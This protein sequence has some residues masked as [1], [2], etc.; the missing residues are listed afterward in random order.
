MAIEKLS[1]FQMVVQKNQW[2]SFRNKLFQKGFIHLQDISKKM[3]PL[4]NTSDEEKTLR[5]RINKINYLLELADRTNP[6][7][8]PFINNFIPDRPILEPSSV[9]K[10]KGEDFLNDLFEEINSVDEKI[11]SSKERLAF[12]EQRICQLTPYEHMAFS[13]EKLAFGRFVNVWLVESKQ[14]T[15]DDLMRL[16][17]FLFEDAMVQEVPSNGDETSVASYVV[18]APGSSYQKV[19]NKLK[20][21]DLKILP[22]QNL[23]GTPAS[24]LAS[25]KEE[26]ASLI[27]TIEES[28]HQIG[29][30]HQKEPH[31]L[32]LK[33]LC[34][35]HL[36]KIEGARNFTS[37]R[38]VV[39]MEGYIPQTASKEAKE[40]LDKS[41]PEVFYQDEEADNDAPIKLNN[42]PFFAPFEFLLRMFGLPRYGMIDPTPVVSFLFLIFFGIAFG[43]VL[44]GLFLFSV[45]HLM[46]K[47]YD[48]DIGTVK[49]LSMFKYAGISSAFFGMI[50]TSWAGDLV[51]TYVPSSWWLH[52]LHH[53]LGI[54]SA[55]EHVMV[56]MVAIIYLGVIA[57]MIAVAM[58]MFQNIKEKKWIDAIFDQ[59]SWMLFMP[60]I[61]IVIGQYLAPGYFPE[62]LVS[63]AGYICY[64]SIAMIFIGGF[65]K[66]K[67]PIT[68]VFSGT[69]NFYGIMSTYGVSALMA[70]VLSYLRLLALAVATSSMAMSFNL[71]SFL[72]KDIPLIGPL[73][74]I[75]VLLLSN[76]LNI[77]LS[78]LGA[79]V[80]PV[81][82][83]F[84]ELFSRFYQSGGREFVPYGQQFKHVFLTK[85]REV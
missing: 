45:C 35:S 48:H 23:K 24:V 3:N 51:T 6:R 63:W 47:K 81:R 66:S 67:N 8:K 70:D 30:L 10:I 79:F 44:Y 52:R 15:R 38:R 85:Q 43:D 31:L 57:Q 2:I 50:T 40:W 82:L 83:L 42:R 32:C 46:S 16:Y 74:I 33:D 9:E 59:F 20:R 64:L 41:W 76:L 17:P 68:G 27:H 55:S 73:L 60:S 28:I 26:K 4:Q 11:S 61:T 18:I 21:T 62:G 56:M 84:Y 29:L 25:L 71:V 34:E 13:F 77:L 36:K 58:A 19:C 80:H 39:V 78:V 53:S 5:S 75:V 49:F 72:F 37:S 65:I 54:I 7:K 69:I 14:S 22:I 12:V 1:K